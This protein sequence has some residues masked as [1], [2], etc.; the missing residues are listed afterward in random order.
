MTCLLELLCWSKNALD[1]YNKAY[2]DDFYSAL[3][4]CFNLT[5]VHATQ[6]LIATV[7]TVYIL[8]IWT[9]PCSLAK[10]LKTGFAILCTPACL[11]L[12]WK[13]QRCYKQLSSILLPGSRSHLK[14]SHRNMKAF[15]FPPR[16][17]TRLV[18]AW[19]VDPLMVV[20]ELETIQVLG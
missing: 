17:Q 11:I 16:I 3:K 8:L 20:N 10:P 6:S 15:Y 4:S 1:H 19:S 18:F 5:R 7:I 13:K 12:W 9:C 14:R 2:S